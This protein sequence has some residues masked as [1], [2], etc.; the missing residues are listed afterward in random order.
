MKRLALVC[1]VFGCEAAPATIAGPVAVAAAESVPAPAT[2]PVVAPTPPVV[3]DGGVPAEPRQVRE[4]LQAFAY[5]E[6]PPQTD[7][8]ATGEH[9]GERL[10]FNELLTRSMLAGAADHPIG[11]AAVR[12]LYSGDLRTLKGFALMLKTGPSGIT[13]EGWFWYEIFGTTAEAE[14]TVAEPGARGC[15]G[16]HAHAVDFVHSPDTPR[17]DPQPL[18]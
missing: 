6:W 5:R 12:E 3:L 17:E 8:R 14:P 1:A 10:F 18:L 15:V 13:G 11:S 16:C 9:G 4:W 2:A 7:I